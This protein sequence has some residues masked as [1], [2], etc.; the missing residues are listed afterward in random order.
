MRKAAIFPAW[1]R[2]LRG[3]QPFLSIEITKECPLHCSGCYAYSPDHLNNGR[4]IRSLSEWRGE[5]LIHK[6][7]ALVRRHRP[8]HVSIVGGEPL[9]RTREVTHILALLNGLGIETQV[10]TSAVRPIPREWKQFSN[11]HLSVS[12]DGLQADHDSRRTP[13]TYERVLRNIDGHAVIV[14]CTIIPKF[15]AAHDYLKDFVHTWSLLKNVRKIWFSLF[16]PQKNEFMPERLSPQDRAVAIDRIAALQSQYPKLYAP[17]IVLRGFRNPPDSPA[18][19]IFAQ[20]T[21]CVSAD[22]ETPILPCQIGGHPECPECGCIA[23]A[24]MTAI[25]NIKLAGVVKLADL[26]ACSKKIGERWRAGKPL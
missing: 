11:L 23:S 8:L 4:S 24:G 21:K 15:L 18:E 10:V 7:M 26:F 19:C 5:E 3:Y 14:H 6:V 20:I 9:V 1:S 17:E 22:L 2:I 12:V 13:A 16:T 25:G